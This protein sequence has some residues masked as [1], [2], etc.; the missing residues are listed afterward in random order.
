[1]KILILSSA[2]LLASCSTTK[3]QMYY[4]TAKSI[5]RDTTVSQSACFAAVTEIAKGG[6]NGVKT[7]AIVL[8]EKCKAETFKL[9]MPKKNILGL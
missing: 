7:G 8:A 1:M 2:L 3:E 4:D 6:D 5:S 9:E